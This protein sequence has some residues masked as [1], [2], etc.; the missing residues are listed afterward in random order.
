[1]LRPLFTTSFLIDDFLDDNGHFG[2]KQILLSSASSKTAVGTAHS[3]ALRRGT[4]GAPKVIG[5]TSAANAGFTRSLGCY[6]TVLT[7]DE[8][9]ELPGGVPTVYVD[10]SGDAELRRRIHGH[11]GQDL[12][13][14]SSV[15]GTHWEALGSARDLP[16]PRPTLFFA[17]ARI[18]LRGSCLLY[19]SPS[20]R[21]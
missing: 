15:G 9:L 21:D 18:K 2:A 11:F 16:G 14:S 19:T 6:D 17:P 12:K 3:L 20:P 5:L 13:F 7:Y 8:G 10:F 1:M 4:P